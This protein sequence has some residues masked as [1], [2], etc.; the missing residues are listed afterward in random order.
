MMNISLIV[1]TSK[2]KIMKNIFIGID[3]SSKTLDICIKEGGLSNSIVIDNNIVSCKK[4]FNR[5]KENYDSVCIA[6]ENT[7][8][9]NYNLYEVLE[10]FSFS[11]YVINP[12]HLKKSLGLVR[13]KNDLI[14]A[15]RIVC[16]IEKNY[17]DLPIWYPNS[18]TIKKLKALQTE[19]K[20]RIKIKTSLLQQQ[21]DYKLM[22]SIKM[23]K[24]LLKLNQNLIKSIEKQLKAIEMKMDEL[25]KADQKLKEQ[26]ERIQTIPGV[27]KVLSLLI[28]TKTQGFNLINNPRKMACY[29]GVVPFE[30]QSGTS[31]RFKPR[32]SFFADKELKKVLHL[33][34]M[35][36]IRLE[37]ELRN[38]YLRK[39]EEGKN[40]MSVLNAIR[41]KIIHRIFALIKNE[42]FY[43]KDFILS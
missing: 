21:A 24:E 14:D 30:Y 7:G 31:L 17:M 1:L 40:K 11:V 41:N 9:Y 33:A 4:F 20:H 6:M 43:E 37:N 15:E 8:R 3:I 36:A 19:R 10:Q 38:Y 28:I 13:G 12:I 35:S 23:D 39:I 22:K 26:S 2:N 32:V 25:L 34:A 16:F 5:F 29:A 27:G 42:S 18:L